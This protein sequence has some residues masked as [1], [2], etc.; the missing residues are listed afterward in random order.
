MQTENKNKLFYYIAH[1][2]RTT[3]AFC[4]GGTLMQTFLAT[5]GFSADQLY[6]HSSIYQA[7]N[8]ATILLCANFADTKS[9]IR[10]VALIQIPS[11]ILY[12]SCIPFCLVAWGCRI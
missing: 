10:R 11:A 7:V 1:A 12:L 6:I 2:M 4:A 9:I 3:A 5:L 8:V